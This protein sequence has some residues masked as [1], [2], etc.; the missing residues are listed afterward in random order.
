MKIIKILFLFIS[1]FIGFISI[2]NVSANDTELRNKKIIA[3]IKERKKLLEEQNTKYLERK[4]MIQK[5]I[6]R[7]IARKRKQKLIADYHRRKNQTKTVTIKEKKNE[8]KSMEPHISEKPIVKSVEFKSA[9]V[10]EKKVQTFDIS[11]KMTYKS[12]QEK[13]LSCELSATSDILSYFTNTKISEISVINKVDKSMYNKLPEIKNGVKIWGNPNAGYVGNIHTTAN[14]VKATQTGMTGYGVLE[15]PIAKIFQK[16]NLNTKIIT[17]NNYNLRYTQQD[18]LK[19]ILTALEQGKMVQLWG[20][21]CTDPRFE[22]TNKKN[23]CSRFAQSRELVWYYEENGKLIKHTGLAGEHAFYLLGY[24]GE[25]EK[26]TDIIV[27]DTNTGKHTY[28]LSEW[29][30]KWNKMQNRSIIISSK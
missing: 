21:Y 1:L 13:S 10:I 3:S 19:E 15:K 20:D 7:I 30:R 9:P 6:K 17:K 2:Q 29:M 18:H 28:P 27:W 4:E 26:P 11:S 22:D 25:K 8:I 23:R 24:V 5:N 14:G 12:I 16:H